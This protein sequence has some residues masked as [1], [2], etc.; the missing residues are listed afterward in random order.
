M[1]ELLMYLTANIPSRQDRQDFEQSRYRRACGPVCFTLTVIKHLL[2][3]KLE[4]QKGTHALV[5]RLLVKR[6][7]HGNM[8]GDFARGFRH[9]RILR[10]PVEQGKFAIFSAG[11]PN[12]HRQCAMLRPGRAFA[13]GPHRFE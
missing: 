5:E 1:V 3:K 2:V 13:R 11:G 8:G 12:P 6:V 7:A 10:H 9:S 4:S